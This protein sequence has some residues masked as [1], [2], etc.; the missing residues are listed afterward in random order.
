MNGEPPLL[1][2]KP[3]ESFGA[4]KPLWKRRVVGESL[5]CDPGCARSS[6]DRMLDRAALTGDGK[7]RQPGRG[8]WMF[9][10]KYQCDHRFPRRVR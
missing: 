8:A 6:S 2:Q 7:K 9:L 4:T 10:R 5:A 1:G 3:L